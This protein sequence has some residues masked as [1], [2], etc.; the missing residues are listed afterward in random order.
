MKWYKK[1]IWQITAMM[2]MFVMLVGVL[3]GL[4][5]I[6]S[7]GNIEDA[8]KHI[9]I[10][11]KDLY[12]ENGLPIGQGL[13]K[14]PVYEDEDKVIFSDRILQLFNP[15]LQEADN[16]ALSTE[17]LR[18][19]FSQ[20]IPFLIMPIP[21]RSVIED[22]GQQKQIYNEFFN[23]FKTQ[24]SENIQYIDILPTLLNHSDEY[25]YFRTDT[26]WTAKAAYYASKVLC[27][28]LGIE[29]IPLEGYEEYMFKEI[30]GSLHL[31]E[32]LDSNLSMQVKNTVEQIPG[33]RIYYYLLPDSANRT[34]IFNYEN[35]EVVNRKK[36]T[37]V[38]SGSGVAT[39]VGG[40]FDWAV[41]EGDS[42]EET[43]KDK[44]VLLLC[45]SDG[46]MVAPYLANYYENVYVVNIANY[47][48]FL[49]EL[50]DFQN[51]YPFD[52]IIYVPTAH[53]LCSEG[54]SKVLDKLVR[55][56]QEKEV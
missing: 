36:P 32:K 13:S 29:P 15:E 31:R 39:F 48:N 38:R 3:Y 18:N 33:D 49:D 19:Q 2:F 30:F 27:E 50:P 42:K 11:R 47:H 41:V 21:P 34:E 20:D 22:Y 4:N 26:L 35:G 24:L 44:S 56:A 37:V 1:P 16:A 46:R 10:T 45:S 55:N 9:S 54:V 5:Y 40:T 12:N 8:T 6:V 28:N 52:E 53:E 14:I 51:K 17:L 43:K 7:F 23:N 25:L